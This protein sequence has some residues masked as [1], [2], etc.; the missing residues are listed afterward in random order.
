[1]KSRASVWSAVYAT[2][3]WRRSSAAILRGCLLFMLPTA[4]AGF[5][6]ANADEVKFTPVFMAGESGYSCFRIPAFVTTKDGTLLAVADGRLSKCSDIPNPLDLVLKRST[7]SGKTWGPLQIIAAYGTDPQDRDVYPQHGITNPVPRVCA[8]DAALLLDRTN[9]RVWV[10][11]DNGAYVKGR[12]YN[13]AIKLE[14]RHSDDNGKTWSGPLDLEANNPGLHSAGTE[15]MASPGNGIQLSAGPHAGRLLF[16]VYTWSN[17][18]SSIV[19]YSD[20]HGSSWKRGGIAAK[21]GGEM[22]VAETSAGKLLAT[23]RTDSLPEKGVRYFNSSV[24]GGKTWGEPYFETSKQPAIP[25]PKCQGSL[26]S[27]SSG[28]KGAVPTLALVNASDATART[29]L[30]L[31]L[32]HDGGITWPEVKL[33]YPG[34]SAYSALTTLPDGDL[35]IMGELDKYHQIAFTRLSASAVSATKP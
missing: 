35:G 24:D 8:G 33:L 30:T 2:A 14:M 18:Y 23:I 32:S 15:N 5:Y 16:C 20:D 13:R 19:V 17:Q 6:R 28:K 10:L 22:Q 1:M 4:A 26:L 9:G 3:F 21:G 7:D 25:D 34:V 29:N 11:Y 12:R 31:R 27:W